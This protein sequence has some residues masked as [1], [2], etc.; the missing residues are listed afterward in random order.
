MQGGRRSSGVCKDDV[1]MIRRLLSLTL[2]LL[3]LALPVASSQELPRH[4]PV[5]PGESVVPVGTLLVDN[6]DLAYLSYIA[7]YQAS[8]AANITGK[9]ITSLGPIAPLLY[10]LY[11]SFLYNDTLSARK[12]LDVLKE[13]LQKLATGDLKDLA[14]S[15]PAQIPA[16]RHSMEL[17]NRN[18]TVYL[19]PNPYIPIEEQDCILP[20]STV[21][22]ES[23]LDSIVTLLTFNETST[24]K[25][26]YIIVALHI[27]RVAAYSNVIRSILKGKLGWDIIQAIEK[28]KLEINET[29]IEQLFISIKNGSK[30]EA[31]DALRT[32]NDYA[33]RGL[34]DWDT[35]ARALKIYRSRFGT[36]ILNQP[37]N[38]TGSEEV[39]VNLTSFLSN[40]EGVVRQAE[41]ARIE[42]GKRGG[43]G[44]FTP[45]SIHVSPLNPG[46]LGFAAIGL[47][48]LAFT[49]ERERLKPA[50][51]M[52]R[53]LFGL[54]PKDA[55]AEWCYRVI[56]NVM[57]IRGLPKYESETP[58]EYL[59][60]LSSLV[61]PETLSFMET[62]TEAYEL[63]VF[64]GRRSELDP[65]ICSREA[66]RLMLSGV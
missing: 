63:E 26:K 13:L 47:V 5:I 22:L 61:S 34:I 54:P 36:P 12:R 46:I 10:Q 33:K 64:A 15:K 20:D 45:P 14:L 48:A 18:V 65:R 19:L 30:T 31:L 44:G 16:C 39:E 55:D 49:V 60:R 42:Y 17:N 4:P 43:V 58:R 52:A 27:P 3:I 66:R 56:I 57:R 1:A 11:E 62:L 23:S 51:N 6:Y 38:K 2:L 21:A 35:Y 59:D 28:G 32:L 29:M 25:G 7:Y 50:A 37:T 53:A 9:K 40:L 8:Y 41:K 24:Y